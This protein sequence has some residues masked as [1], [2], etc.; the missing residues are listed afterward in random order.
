MKKVTKNFQK[1]IYMNC[2]KRWNMNL[3]GKDD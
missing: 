3:G 2:R 1:Y